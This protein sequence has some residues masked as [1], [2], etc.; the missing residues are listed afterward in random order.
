MTML[1]RE[2]LLKALEELEKELAEQKVRAEIFF[3]LWVERQW[4]LPTTRE[5][6]RQT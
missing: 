4:P 1:D 2:Q 6:Q 5:G 3:L